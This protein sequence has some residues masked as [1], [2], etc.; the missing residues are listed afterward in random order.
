MMASTCKVYIA[1]D[2][3]GAACVVG[4]PA[5]DGRIGAWQLDYVRQRATEEATAAVLGARETGA[6]DILVHDVG[7]LRGYSPVGNVL[8]Y[9]ELPRGTRIAL[10]GAPI[11][12]VAAE[13]FDAAFLLGHHAMAGDP[14]GV[15]AHTFSTVSI[16]SV[17][18]NGQPIGEIGI[19]SLQPVSY[20]HLRAHET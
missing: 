1:V 16:A 19:E 6:T 14:S 12:Q 2:S 9:D 4:E 17:H 13:G 10:G 3:E 18:L 7:F 5:G 20:T 15:M 11:K 8:L